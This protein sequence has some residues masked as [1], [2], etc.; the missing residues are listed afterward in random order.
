M[1]YRTG[2]LYRQSIK[3]MNKL[4]SDAMQCYQETGNRQVIC[5]NPA[6]C[7][8]Y[9]VDLLNVKNGEIVKVIP[10]LPD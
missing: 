6:T 8:H 9:I 2:E 7:K 1:I 4:E 3:L 5:F 10:E